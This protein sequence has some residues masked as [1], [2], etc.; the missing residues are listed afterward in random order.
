VRQTLYRP[1]KDDKPTM[2][3]ETAA[4]LRSVFAP[5]VRELDVLLGQ[6]ISRRWGYRS[7]S[8]MHSAGD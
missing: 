1:Y 2:A 7:D 3:V 5:D 8:P 6:D 4:H